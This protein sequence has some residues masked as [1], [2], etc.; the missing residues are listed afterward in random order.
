MSAEDY[1]G[2]SPATEPGPHYLAFYENA[3]AANGIAYDVYDVD[4]ARPHG[5][6]PARCPE[7]LR[8]GAVVHRR[9]HRGAGARPVC[10]HVIAARPAGAVLDP[11]FHERGRPVLYVG[12]NAGSAVHDRCHAVLRPVREPRLRGHSDHQAPFCR[13]LYGSGDGVNDV[14]EYWLGAGLVNVGAGA[15][16]DDEGNPQCLRRR[17][18]RRPFAGLGR[19]DSTARQRRATRTDSCRRSSRPA[20]SCR[21]TSTRSST[22]GRRRATTGRVGRSTRTRATLRVLADRRRV[23]QAPDADGRR[24]RRATRLSFWTSYDTEPD[25][26]FV[27]V[28]AQKAGQDAGRRCRTPT[29]TRPARRRAP[30][31]RQAGDALHPW[32]EHYQ[33]LNAGGDVPARP[34]GTDR[35]SGTPRR[36]PRGGWQQWQIDLS[37]FAGQEIELSIAYASDWADPGPGRCSST[38]VTASV[39]IARSFETDLGGWAVAGP[40]AG[41]RP[42]REQLTRITGAGFPEGAAVTT[43]A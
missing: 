43:T 39:A 8:R 37:E 31:A 32:L 23:V 34:T 42:E 1:T 19:G 36:A 2:L 21:P 22:A 7:P 18:R 16:F 41:Q 10:R 9:R 24:C 11:R 4:D 30:A 28:E 35:A 14:L 15:N 40:P 27:F 20:A 26:D 12:K 17:G 13:P 3:L 29:G 25:W 33:T 5:A 38:D 6:G